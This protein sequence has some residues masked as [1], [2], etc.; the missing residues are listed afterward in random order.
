MTIPSAKV[1]MKDGVKSNAETDIALVKS[2]R[3]MDSFME[4]NQ[5]LAHVPRV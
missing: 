2:R 5:N 1:L 3:L 4:K